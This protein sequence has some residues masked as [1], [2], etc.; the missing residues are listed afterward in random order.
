MPQETEEKLKNGWL[1]NGR[2]RRL[3]TRGIV[4][5]GEEERYDHLGRCSMSIREI[6]EVLYRH[7][8]VS[9]RPSVGIPTSIGGR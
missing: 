3:T 2:P 9:R 5:R 4:H 6:E 7:P 1:H 8:A